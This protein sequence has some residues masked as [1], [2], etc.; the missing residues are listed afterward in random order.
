MLWIGNQGLHN[1]FLSTQTTNGQALLSVKCIEGVGSVGRDSYTPIFVP[2]RN[3]HV[4]PKMGSGEASNLVK[5]TKA[6]IWPHLTNGRW[7]DFHSGG[8]GS[9]PVGVTRIGSL[10]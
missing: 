2:L 8:T 5:Y 9:N 7:P 10:S 6:H 3:F 1:P 4:F